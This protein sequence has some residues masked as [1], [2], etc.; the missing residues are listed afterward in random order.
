[1]SMFTNFRRY[2]A[3][4]RD[5]RARIRTAM[6]VANLPADMRKDIGWPD[7]EGFSSQP[8]NLGRPATQTP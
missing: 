2:V 8:A 4:Q 5:M 1:M 7:S 3:R 6:Y